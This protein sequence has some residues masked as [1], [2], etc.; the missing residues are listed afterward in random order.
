MTTIA[1]KRIEEEE[2]RQLNLP[3]CLNEDIAI[4]I[5][6]REILKLICKKVWEIDYLRNK[7]DIRK[8][9]KDRFILSDFNYL[10]VL[11]EELREMDKTNSKD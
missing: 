7:E 5:A 11:V 3:R 1:I 10:W 6:E 4:T 2:P 8:A 9:L